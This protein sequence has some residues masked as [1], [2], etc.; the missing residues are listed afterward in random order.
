MVLPCIYLEGDSVAF[1]DCFPISFTEFTKGM[2]RTIAQKTRENKTA[3]NIE[4]EDVVWI[5]EM[6]AKYPFAQECFNWEE[7]AAAF[8][9]STRGNSSSSNQDAGNN[10]VFPGETEDRP[11]VTDDDLDAIY[12]DLL[13]KRRDRATEVGAE[14][15]LRFFAIRPLQG[16]ATE[17]R[18]GL[19]CDAWQGCITDADASAWAYKYKIQDTMRFSVRDCTE[20]HAQHSPH[21]FLHLCVE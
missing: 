2:P 8:G 15:G 6:L 20:P 18:S 21:S 14:N 5:M 7:Q 1:S 11:L 10:R 16:K 12:S 9:A 4:T 3:D 19:L 17:K 13:D